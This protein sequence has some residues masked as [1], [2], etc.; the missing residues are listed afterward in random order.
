MEWSAD[1][2]SAQWWVDALFPFN[3]YK[4][5]STVPDVFEAVT[6]IF[7]PIEGSDGT[8]RTWESLAKAAGRVAHADMQLHAIAGKEFG[9]LNGDPYCETGTLPGPLTQ[10]LAAALSKTTGDQ[11]CW[12]GFSDIYGNVQDAV[13]DDLP[14]AGS[15]NRSYY[16]ASAPLAELDSVRALASSSKWGQTPNLWWPKDRSWF[17]ATEVDFMWTYVAG[18]RSVVE[19]VERSAGLEAFRTGF[20]A[21]HTVHGDRINK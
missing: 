17:V 11:P 1:V 16:L 12:F 5:G 4:V 15:R 20:D 19:D 9:Q 3:S 18:S 10:R 13:S 14:Q 8:E 7:H 2:R 21:D 6:R